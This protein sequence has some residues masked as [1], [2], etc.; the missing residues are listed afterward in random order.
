DRKRATEE[1]NRAVAVIY[2]RLGMSGDEGHR[3]GVV[4]AG[5]L[6]RMTDLDRGSNRAI[7]RSALAIPKIHRPCRDRPILDR[8]AQVQI[9]ILG[10][11]AAEDG[12]Y[13][14]G[15]SSR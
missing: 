8:H 10:K 1:M 11:G 5:Q 15:R 6:V 3:T 7:E 13:N 4:A 12:R 14:A 2:G 9:E